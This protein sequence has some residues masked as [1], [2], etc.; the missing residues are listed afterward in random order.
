MDSLLVRGGPVV[1]LVAHAVAKPGSSG[2]RLGFTVTGG[3]DEHAAH[4]VAAAQRD[5]DGAERPAAH[6][7]PMHHKPRGILLGERAG[8]QRL[9]QHAEE[10]RGLPVCKR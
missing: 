8:V 4:R 5:R 7:A 2:A 6:V 9:F 3:P 1:E 10:L